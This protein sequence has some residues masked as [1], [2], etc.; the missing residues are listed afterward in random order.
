[1]DSKSHH[2][3]RQTI[4]KRAENMQNQNKPTG[5]LVAS[6]LLALMGLVTIFVDICVVAMVIFSFG[7]M[8]SFAEKATESMAKIQEQKISQVSTQDSLQDSS[9]QATPKDTL[10]AT[11]EEIRQMGKLGSFFFKGF[12]LLVIP[13]GILFS[14]IGALDFVAAW[15]IFKLKAWARV[16]GTVM[17][18]L[19]LIAFP[20]GTVIGLA[21]ICLLWIGK[22]VKVAFSE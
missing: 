10:K 16:L 11:P 9:K 21:I 7:F 13:F 15:G 12:S 14:V 2:V 5:V 3:E 4:P 18:V 22:S 20:I 17:A 8:G 1:L 6:V 19:H